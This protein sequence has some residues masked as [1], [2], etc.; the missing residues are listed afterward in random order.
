MKLKYLLVIFSFV[1]LLY[2]TSCSGND[3]TATTDMEINATMTINGKVEIFKFFGHGI[4]TREEGNELSIDLIRE[5]TEPFNEKLIRIVHPYQETGRNI[6]NRFIYS[7]KTDDSFLEGDFL[8]G[9]FESNIITSTNNLFQAT[10]SG[11]HTIQGKEIIITDGKITYRFEGP[12][13]E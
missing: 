2:L 9:E 12:I 8:N 7:E 4:N 5:E 1:P 10:F 11:T 3:D 6:T 13:L